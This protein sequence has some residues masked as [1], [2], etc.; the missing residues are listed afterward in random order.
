MKHSIYLV[1][2]YFK[3]FSEKVEFFISPSK[4][5]TLGLLWAIFTKA[6]PENK[7]KK[8]NSKV[9]IIDKKTTCIPYATLV[10]MLSPI[11]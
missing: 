1:G 4:A 6:L 5:I 2:S 3:R 7:T 10:A 11:L 9:E 8:N